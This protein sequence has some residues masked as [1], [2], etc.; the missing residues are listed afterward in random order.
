[1]IRGKEMDGT[2]ITFF[3]S[4]PEMMEKVMEGSIEVVHATFNESNHCNW[5]DLFEGYDEL[6][7]IT[8]S[9]GIQ[10]VE[11]VIDMFEYTELIFGCEDLV[12]G[13]FAL[14]MSL[15]MKMAEKLAKSKIA[16]KMAERI[17][18]KKLDI[19]VSRDIKS[20]EKIF[21]LKSKEG[22]TR[23][24]TGSANMS[25]SAFLGR[26]R[27]DI[28]CFD[29][30][31]AYVHYKDRFD[32]FKEKCSDSLSDKVLVKLNEDSDYLKDHIEEIPILKTIE[33][34]D[35]VILEPTNLVEEAEFVADIKA[36]E[37]E[38]KPLV[39]KQKE[40][41][42]KILITG[43][44]KKAFKRKYDDY[45]DVKKEKKKV[46]PILHIDYDTG[47]LFFNE[48][49]LELHQNPEIIKKDINCLHSYIESLSSFIGNT[50][51]GQKDYY[52]FMNW[53]FASPF[54][55]YLRY[56]GDKYGYGIWSFPAIAILY[57]NS[58]G[59][60]T[61][62]ATLLSK[63][64]S[65]E[66]IRPNKSDDFTSTNIHNLKCVCEGLPINI[67]DLAKKQYDAHFE[68]VIKDD[69][70][71]ISEHK[72]NY[73]AIVISTNKLPTLKSE[74][75]KRVVTCRININIEKE[76]GAKNTKRITDSFRQATNAFYCEYFARMLP[77]VEKM[78]EKMKE[79][80]KSY[81]PDILGES[82]LVLKNMFQEYLG[83]LPEYVSEFTYSSYF[84]DDVIGKNMIRKIKNAYRSEP[85]S[86]RVD[87][88]KN[89]L[90]Y[91]YPENG[92][93][94]ELQYFVNE[95]PPR[96]EAEASSRC[97]TMKYDV[98]CE[99]FSETFKKRWFGN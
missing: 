33:K 99:V 32:E 6:Y 58:N 44:V 85:K 11:K 27:E 81:F 83:F 62:F 67:D 47:K 52:R 68:K 28:V 42:G 2:Q 50:K 22:K 69:N 75:S 64:M 77:I 57:G 36:L 82:S 45:A 38:F 88:K 12:D 72:F 84:G 71:G 78:I 16:L 94:Y 74:I 96:L 56:Y 53:Y 5:R 70:W 35:V 48:R 66:N 41:E 1:M 37:G 4:Q 23:V 46:L 26:Q 8:Y 54:M 79:G 60:K 76:T 59:G 98:A 14:V 95:L 19:C 61:T 93:Y 97:L 87:V 20:H 39:S 31:K 10:F 30:E 49:E 73:P 15:H 18:E 34:R 89:L 80:D 13:D 40:K 43:D 25:A 86:F 7:G 3:D 51:D 90:I 9:S 91:T 29:D 21:I 55:P 24:I 63:L 17:K 92:N 65:G